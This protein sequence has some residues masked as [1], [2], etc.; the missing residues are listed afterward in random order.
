MKMGLVPCENMWKARSPA[1]LGPRCAQGEMYFVQFDPKPLPSGALVGSHWW[2]MFGMSHAATSCHVV[3]AVSFS[4]CFRLFML[5]NVVSCCLFNQLLC[6]FGSTMWTLG[7]LGWISLVTHVWHVTRCHK[8]SC[9]LRCHFHVVLCGLM[10]FNRFM[11]LI[12]P[13]ALHIWDHLRDI[14]RWGWFF[15]LI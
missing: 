8:L 14:L 9:C 5:F 10:W 13:A 1:F 6:I 12:S 11:L 2:H 4:C 7:C 15:Q 3:D